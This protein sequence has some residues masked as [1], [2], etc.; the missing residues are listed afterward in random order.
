MQGLFLPH[1]PADVLQPSVA[2]LLE[3]MMQEQQVGD[4]SG[5]RSD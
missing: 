5:S 1:S 3:A 4:G 2:A